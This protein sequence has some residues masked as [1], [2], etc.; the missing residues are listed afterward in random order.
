[1]LKTGFLFKFSLLY[2]LKYENTKISYSHFSSYFN[3]SL[4]GCNKS[5]C[6]VKVNQ[7]T[8]FKKNVFKFL[9]LKKK[10]TV[11]DPIYSVLWLAV[12]LIHETWPY[13]VEKPWRSEHM[14][15]SW[16]ADCVLS[17]S[18][19]CTGS[20]LVSVIGLS[21]LALE[22]PQLQEGLAENWTRAVSLLPQGP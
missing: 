1:M 9:N 6:Y 15:G 12:R 22:K 20:V 10:Y 4:F 3:S 13:R 8:T 7:I 11:W 18:W 14:I 17:F 5:L 19:W 16:V 21:C 2:S